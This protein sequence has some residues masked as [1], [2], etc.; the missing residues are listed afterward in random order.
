MKYYL[1]VVAIIF[2]L[3]MIARLVMPDKSKRRDP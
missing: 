2:L 3:A 1:L